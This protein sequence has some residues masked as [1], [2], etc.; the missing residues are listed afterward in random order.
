M[1][2]QIIVDTEDDKELPIAVLLFNGHEWKLRTV[3]PPTPEMMKDIKR[4][5]VLLEKSF[6]EAGF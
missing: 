4:A 5:L 6:T 2:T 1:F 3:Q